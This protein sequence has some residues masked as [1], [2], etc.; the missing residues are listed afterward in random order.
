MLMIIGSL[1]N[2][3]QSGK[4]DP[5]GF[6]GGE[7]GNQGFRADVNALPGLYPPPAATRIIPIRIDFNPN[8]QNVNVGHFNNISMVMDASMFPIPLLQRV[9]EGQSIEGQGMHIVKY[10]SS[11]VLYPNALRQHLLSSSNLLWSSIT[12]DLHIFFIHIYIWHSL[13]FIHFIIW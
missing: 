8:A 5:F 4:P 6:E 2:G 1:I 11:E 12:H 3:F 10:D 9:A 7:N 13:I